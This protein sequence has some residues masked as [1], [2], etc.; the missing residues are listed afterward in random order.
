QSIPIFPKSMIKAMKEIVSEQR[1]INLNDPTM[2]I[3]WGQ[4]KV[5]GKTVS[6]VSVEIESAP[7]IEPIYFNEWMLPDI[8]LK[9]TSSNGLYA[10]IGVPEGLH[11]VLGRRGE[12]YFSH[13]N[14]VVQRGAVA[15]GDL[16]SAHRAELAPLRI[17]DAFTGEP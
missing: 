12:Q 6:G 10:F 4:A 2:P 3:I 13:Q 1:M 9:A 11:A 15:I 17:Y 8:N 16:E 14:V 5:D 7:S